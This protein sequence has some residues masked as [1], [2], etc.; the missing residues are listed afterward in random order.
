MIETE[1]GTF[2][3]P[4]ELAVLNWSF[5][6]RTDQ[7]EA[8]GRYVR[9]LPRTKVRGLRIAMR[10]IH[11]RTV[12]SAR[13]SGDGAPEAPVPV[14]DIPRP[15]QVCVPFKA[16]P[17]AAERALR[18][19]IIWVDQATRGTS[20][21]RIRR[22]DMD[23]LDTLE[24]RLVRDER[25]KA[26]EAPRVDPPPVRP[27]ASLGVL[28][29]VREVLED[30]RVAGLDRLDQP[31]REDVVAVAAETCQTVAETPKMS[32]GRSGAFALEPAA[33]RE[34]SFFDGPPSG[35]AQ[36]FSVAHY[37][38]AADA[39]IHTHGV[40]RI[41]MVGNLLLHDDVQKPAFLLP[42]EVC[43]A[44][45]KPL[46]S[47]G[48]FVEENRKLDPAADRRQPR[49]AVPVEPVRAGV[50]SDGGIRGLWAAYFSA[51]LRPF[52]DGLESLDRLPSCRDHKL[53][54]QIELVSEIGVSHSVE[55]D[56][57]RGLRIPPCF[58]HDV[59]GRS[60]LTDGLGQPLSLRGI[61]D[62]PQSDGLCDSHLS[63]YRRYTPYRL[64]NSRGWR[65]L[66]AL[67][68]GVSAPK[69]L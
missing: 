55:L 12:D 52:T 36:E 45:L 35:I 8:F 21:T 18:P 14:A 26:G 24:R 59:E 46:E 40:S 57:V 9:Q 34:Q 28:P 33:K 37:G 7:L 63:L 19:S 54:G 60:V 25:S 23:D 5:Q 38:G 65:F 62:E 20:P 64:S 51:L 43:G 15:Y 13:H 4:W 1:E 17:D 6:N 41:Y 69:I 39:T 67:K 66:P 61:N 53:A 50:E 10:H 29:D 68:G 2:E 30:E 48:V 11:T 16:A 49:R 56:A 3:S 58:G 47:L 27:S 44:N 42:N 22:I 31:L 32:T